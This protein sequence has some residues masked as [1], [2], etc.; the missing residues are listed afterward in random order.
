MTVA[1]IPIV[2]GAI[3]MVMKGWEKE[4]GR[5]GNRRTNRYHPNY[6]IVEIGQNTEKSPVHLRRLSV[7]QTP[8]KDHRLTPV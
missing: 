7:T 1:V 5:V 2:I 6:R 3:R 8:V 4:A